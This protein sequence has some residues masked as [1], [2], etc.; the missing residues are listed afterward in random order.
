M[1]GILLWGIERNGTNLRSMA[2]IRWQT[3]LLVR[4]VGGS[5]ACLRAE[6]N[7]RRQF[8]T[9]FIIGHASYNESQMKAVLESIRHKVE[10]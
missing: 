6:C 9:T 2:T 4:Y 5:V 7:F 8:Q 10:T 3:N 1:V